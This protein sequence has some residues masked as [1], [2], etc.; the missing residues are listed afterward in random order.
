[1]DEEEL[2][3]RTKVNSPPTHLLTESPK[4][5]E[6]K[7]EL[8][9]GDSNIFQT[10][11]ELARS[12]SDLNRLLNRI[13]PR[14]IKRKLLF[15][16]LLKKDGGD[17]TKKG[18]SS[19]CCNTPNS[20]ETPS[21]VYENIDVEN[22][23]RIHKQSKTQKNNRKRHNKRKNRKISSAQEIW[24]TEEIQNISIISDPTSKQCET[25]TPEC[26]EPVGVNT[27]ASRSQTTRINDENKQQSKRS[28]YIVGDSLLKDVKGLEL[29]KSCPEDEKIYVKPFSGS[30]VKDRKS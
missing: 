19:H 14:P 26:L 8:I 27:A 21:G 18:K 16:S 11:A 5:T 12:V 3:K 17:E 2:Q 13:K 1:M 22:F 29:K 20:G 9:F 23:N 28:T 30:T 24:N 7:E 6:D 15:Q 4:A 10:I 25:K